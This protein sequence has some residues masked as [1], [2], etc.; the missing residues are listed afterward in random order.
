M[1]VKQYLGCRKQRSGAAKDTLSLEKIQRDPN[2]RKNNVGLE[3]PG[4]QFSRE[5]CGTGTQLPKFV[6][7]TQE[8]ALKA[9]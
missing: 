7:F 4:A 8:Q 3:H 9:V 6:I 1:S 5:G 2:L